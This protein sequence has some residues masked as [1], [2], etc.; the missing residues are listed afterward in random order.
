MRLHKE[1]DAVG[2]L[3]RQPNIPSERTDKPENLLHY[4]WKSSR[5]GATEKKI[6]SGSTLE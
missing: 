2:V 3:E 6:Y 1:T 5:E 4:T